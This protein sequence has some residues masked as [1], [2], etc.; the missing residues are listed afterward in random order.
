MGR[1]GAS[2]IGGD[3]E[4]VPGCDVDLP[5]RRESEC[6][7]IALGDGPSSSVPSCGIGGGC[8]QSDGRPE[9]GE[10]GSS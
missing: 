2:D 9:V 10:L 6:D 1:G 7:L 4:G 5:L 8:V 3:P